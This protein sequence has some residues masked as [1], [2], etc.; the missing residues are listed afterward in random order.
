M[1]RRIRPRHQ[2][3]SSDSPDYFTTPFSC[4]FHHAR[5]SVMCFTNILET[6]GVLIRLDIK[7]NARA[8]LCTVYGHHATFAARFLGAAFHTLQQPLSF[9]APLES[10]LP[11]F[12]LVFLGSITVGRLSNLYQRFHPTSTN[13]ARVDGLLLFGFWSPLCCQRG[14]SSACSSR[15]DG[16]SNRTRCTSD[17]ERTFIYRYRL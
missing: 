4:S 17:T 6:R 2:R 1:R 16:G 5:V 8:V 15:V 7:Q 12:P 13:Y 3:R 14:S 11:P 10:A 9:S